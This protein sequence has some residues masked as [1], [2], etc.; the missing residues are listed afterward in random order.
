MYNCVDGGFQAPSKPA[1]DDDSADNASDGAASA[2][3]DIENDASKSS[4][5]VVTRRSTRRSNTLSEY[6]LHVNGNK[7]FILTMLLQLS[8]IALSL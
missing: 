7:H 6:G 8:F 3:S 1:A 4:T 5:P 2:H